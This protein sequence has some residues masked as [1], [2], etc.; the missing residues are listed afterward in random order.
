MMPANRWNGGKYIE[1]Y[2]NCKLPRVLVMVL[3]SVTVGMIVAEFH[4]FES[5]QNA[6][7]AVH[8]YDKDY[9][10]ETKSGGHFE[11]MVSVNLEALPANG[12]FKYK[13]L[14]LQ[15]EVDED[16][17]RILEVAGP[18]CG[19][20]KSNIANCRGW[21]KILVTQISDFYHI[22][23]YYWMAGIVVGESSST[24]LKFINYAGAP[25]YWHLYLYYVTK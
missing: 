23:R 13:D 3:L 11:A 19:P 18:A 14:I 1:S 7:N 10:L 2:V 16:Y 4:Q 24:T 17:F 25:I 20:E 22:E 9:E 21:V 15:F 6:M 8:H 12:F 5:E